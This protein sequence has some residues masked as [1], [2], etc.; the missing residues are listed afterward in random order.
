MQLAWYIH[1]LAGHAAHASDR[2]HA[3]VAVLEAVRL[4]IVRSRRYPRQ[5]LHEKISLPGCHEAAFVTL[6]R[7]MPPQRFFALF[8]PIEF[9]LHLMRVDAV[10]KVLW[11][12]L[13]LY[14]I[15]VG[16]RAKHM[17]RTHAR[18]NLHHVLS[19][20][21]QVNNTVRHHGSK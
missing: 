14:N 21:V 6:V 4:S 2:I 8:V 16:D 11:E 20:V 5:K 15:R 12:V 13:E 18:L 3:V 7:L 17:A 1:R 10:L 9:F 19:T